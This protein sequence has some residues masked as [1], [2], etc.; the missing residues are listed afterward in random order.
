M[1][2]MALAG[3]TLSGAGLP[4][5]GMPNAGIRGPTLPCPVHAL[6]GTATHR[7]NARPVMPARALADFMVASETA[8]R[9]LVRDCKYPPLGRVMQHSEARAAVTGFLLSEP[10][11]PAR[12][13]SVAAMLRA[14]DGGSDF[15]AALWARN[16][17]YVERFAAVW[18]VMSW[19]AAVV[20]AGGSVGAFDLGGVRITLDLAVRL[21]R[22]G[23]RNRRWM[24]GAM[25]RY[26]AGRAL[27]AEVAAW[28]SALLLAVLRGQATEAAEPDPG[29]C[30]TVDGWAGAAHAA[31]SDAVRRAGHLAAACAS[32]AERWAAVAPPA[33]AVLA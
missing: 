19:P 9:T 11:E 24:G 29:L 23:R 12:L 21:E 7:V 32:I 16:A 8:R 15:M 5:A 28:Q 2:T 3:P 30:L 25:L 31:P 33:A 6:P 20:T 26:A 4:G 1:N 13:E 18:P 27:P 14:R 10:R 17:A 22:T